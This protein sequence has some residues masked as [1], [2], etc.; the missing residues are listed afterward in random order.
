MNAVTAHWQQYRTRKVLFWSAVL[1][2]IP[3]MITWE[4][5]LEWPAYGGFAFT[6]LLVIASASY[7]AKFKCPRCG[8]N[9]ILR[10]AYGNVLTSKC[11]HCGLNAHAH[12]DE[13]QSQNYSLKER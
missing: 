4:V 8:R 11:L 6:L 12:P 3:I 1:A 7:Y 10:T 9:Y 5:A 2:F 13:I